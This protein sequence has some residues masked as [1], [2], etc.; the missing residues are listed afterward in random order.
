MMFSL[1]YIF[2]SQANLSL[3]LRCKITKIFH[4]VQQI[5]N[6]ISLKQLFDMLSWIKSER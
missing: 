2:F 1:P 6:K 5:R 3:F 4:T